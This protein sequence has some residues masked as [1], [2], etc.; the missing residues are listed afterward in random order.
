MKNIYKNSALDI[1]DKEILKYLKNNTKEALKLG[2]RGVANKINTTPSKIMRIAKKLNY[3]GFVEMLYSF[4]YN[5]LMEYDNLTIEIRKKFFFRVRNKSEIDEFLNLINTSKIALYGE[6][7]SSIISEY[8]Y[9]KLLVLGIEP[10][11]IQW[12]DPQF[13][14]NLKT[15]IDLILIVSK[16]GETE[17]CYEFARIIKELGGKVASFT[18]NNM[19]K[20]SQISD[21]AFYFEDV[22]KDDDDIFYPNPFFGYC[23]IGFEELISK[24]FE[25]YIFNV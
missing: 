16:S 1:L 5:D 13:F 23:I 15:K 18:G 11:H 20:I 7:F 25:K 21:Y 14:K 24:Y 2:V 19:S 6:G 22:F 4:K 10:I 12:I 17:S 9:Q 8:I 3:S